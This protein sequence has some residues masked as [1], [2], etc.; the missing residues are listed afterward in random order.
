MPRLEGRRYHNIPAYRSIEIWA[1]DDSEDDDGE[2]MDIAFGTVSDP[3][4]SERT[5]TNPCCS[6]LRGKVRP[7]NE[8]R[9][10]FEDNEFTEVTVTNRPNKFEIPRRLWVSFAD[11]ELEASEGDFEYGKVATVRVRLARHRAME[12]E[13]DIPISVE[14]MGGATRADT[15]PTYTSIPSS[16]TFKPGQTEQT[17]RVAARDDSVDD[18]G[19][20]LKLSFGELPERVSTGETTTTGSTC[21]ITTFP[22]CRSP[23]HSPATRRPS[24]PGRIAVSMPSWM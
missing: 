9:V 10:W 1:I 4:V 11:A 8:T 21:S 15:I 5:G 7:Y 14:W 23:S 18:D 12:R 16:I 24:P 13:V 20:W 19:E 3:Y 22:R 6:Q 17:F 2:Y